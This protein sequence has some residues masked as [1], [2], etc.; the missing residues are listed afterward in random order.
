MPVRTSGGC[1]PPVKR[2]RSWNRAARTVP[3]HKERRILPYR[4]EQMFRLVADVERYPEFLPWCVGARIRERR[5][6]RILA[7]LAVGFMGIRE[8][9]SSTVDI[10]D[11]SCAIRM[12]SDQRPFHH[13]DGRWKFSV[14]ASENGCEVDFSVNFEFRSRL[15]G[16]MMS[17][18]FGEAVRHMVAAFERRAAEI[19]GGV[20]TAP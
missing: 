4:P 8:S 15:L 20:V 9:F 16:A 3:Q 11:Q 5:G 19:Y 7:D 2:P 18:V 1:A 14:D 12:H 6:N 13:L 17:R 10:D